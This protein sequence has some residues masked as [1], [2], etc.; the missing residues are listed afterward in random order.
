M[1]CAPD[2]ILVVD[3]EP[4][5]VEVVEAFLTSRGYDV[6]SALSGSRALEIL[7]HEAVSLVL[8]DLMLPDLAGEEL[9]A[10]IRRTSRVPVIMLTA[11]TSEEDM[12]RGLSLGADDYIAKPF[13]LKALLAR[14]EAVLRRAGSDIRPL[15]N[16]NAFGDLEVDFEAMEV[17]K[18]GAAVPLTPN[19]WRIL[20]ALIKYPSK[21]F[22]R[23]E[24]ICA[25]LGDEFDGFHRA[26][27]THVKNIRQKLE[28]DPK[29]PVYIL[30][31]HGV[32]YRFG[33]GHART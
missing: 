4:K 10:R 32:G 14:V 5:I 22:T 6:L 21:V 9:C 28:D 12:I 17:R 23:D 15:Y 31:V 2:R 18:S 26:I 16:R 30:T 1:K 13:S 27:D 8:L 29:N 7:A 33:G 20:S 24:L 19:E 25:A 3:D 11:K